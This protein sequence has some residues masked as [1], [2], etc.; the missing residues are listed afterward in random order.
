M[1]AQF[2][3]SYHGWQLHNS[4]WRCFK[5]CLSTHILLAVLAGTLIE[6]L[7]HWENDNLPA[8]L[9][10]DPA[11]L[12]EDGGGVS[13]TV[14]AFRYGE[15]VAAVAPC[16]LQRLAARELARLMQAAHHPVITAH[17]RSSTAVWRVIKS[18]L[19][20]VGSKLAGGH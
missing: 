8:A 6:A 18:R 9:A 10:A 4:P 16:S 12:T 14:L 3:L 20:G 5:G 17:R 2:C 15:A 7:L 1:S 13:A 11:A 19:G